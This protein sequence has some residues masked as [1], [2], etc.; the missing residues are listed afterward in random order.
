M[1]I[2]VQKNIKKATNW[3]MLR[4]DNISQKVVE[5]IKLAV[6][7]GSL[8]SINEKDKIRI[9][10]CSQLFVKCLYFQ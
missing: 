5:L 2:I 6:I 9:N 3:E 1:N 7:K 4:D 8:K 10:L